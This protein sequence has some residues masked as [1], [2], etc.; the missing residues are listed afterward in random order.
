MVKKEDAIKITKL[1]NLATVLE[2]H[3][4]MESL[5]GREASTCSVCA[6][7]RDAWNQQRM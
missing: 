2:A 7:S 6:D 4:K 1:W 5:T 3:V